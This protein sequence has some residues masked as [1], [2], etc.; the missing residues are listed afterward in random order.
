MKEKLS[1]LSPAKISFR[2]AIF[3]AVLG[4]VGK[5]LPGLDGLLGWVLLLGSAALFYEAWIRRWSQ[6]R[7][8]SNLL[9]AGLLLAGS[10]VLLSGFL[11]LASTPLLALGAVCGVLGAVAMISESRG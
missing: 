3:A 7:L 4:Y 8:R 9:W 11:A 5:F 2:V 10:L 6:R 1:E